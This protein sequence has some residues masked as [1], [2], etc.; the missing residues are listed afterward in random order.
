MQITTSGLR[1]PEIQEINIESF[2]V[3]VTILD[4][5]LTDTDIHVNAEKI[6]EITEPDELEIIDDSDTNKT[7]WGKIKKSISTLINHM[8]MVASETTSGHI[9]IGA[10]L[11]MKE[12]AAIVKIAN[13]LVTEESDTALSA[14]M[15][16]Y[17]DENKAPTNHAAT[18]SIYGLGNE[19]NYGHVKLSDS[20]TLS[21]GDSLEGV[22]A[23]SKAVASSYQTLTNKIALKADA[24][25]VGNVSDISVRGVNSLV[26]AINYT[27]NMTNYTLPL[28]S[29]SGTITDAIRVDL[30]NPYGLNNKPYVVAYGITL[31]NLPDD[32]AWGIRE[33]LW[34]SEDKVMVRITGINKSGTKPVFYTNCYNAGYWTGWSKM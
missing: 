15:G 24:A 9:K 27:A 26:Q 22:G 18:T 28:A 29:E 31:Y 17:L 1:K 2:G 6:A 34:I 32:I 25:D 3:N 14:A 20:F 19:T 23:S 16:K 13:D 4:E 21:A 7:M 33:V 8:Q 30:T 11:E 12:G 10:G 5:H